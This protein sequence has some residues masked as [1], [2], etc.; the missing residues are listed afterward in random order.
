MQWNV[1]PGPVVL[2]VAEA[3]KTNGWN[4][5]LGDFYLTK[6]ELCQHPFRIVGSGKLCIIIS[7]SSS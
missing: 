1:A 3:I 6:T 5:I 4:N 7:Q 2:L